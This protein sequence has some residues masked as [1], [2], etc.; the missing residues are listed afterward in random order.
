MMVQMEFGKLVHIY[1]HS[2]Y[3]CIHTNW[4]SIKPWEERDWIRRAEAVTPQ[5]S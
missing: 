5:E 3:V 2:V 1:L 4:A